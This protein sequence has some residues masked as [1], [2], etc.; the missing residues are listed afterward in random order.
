MRVLQHGVLHHPH[1]RV[2]LRATLLLALLCGGGLAV[3]HPAAAAPS[4]SWSAPQEVDG[5][6]ALRAVS[7]PS[8][9]LCVAVD[10]AG[11]AVV[12]ARA[13]NGAWSWSTFAIDGGRPLSSVSCPST[14]LCVAV[15][16]EGRA[17]VGVDP[18]VGPGAWSPVTIDAA[19]PLASISCPSNGL[20][21]AVDNKG[22]VLA[23][24]NPAAAAPGA[25]SAPAAIA[26][27][28]TSVSCAS[29]ALC[30][31]VDGEGHALTS[32]EPTA[33]AGAWHRRLIDPALGLTAVSCYAGGS[34]VA[35]DGVGNALASAD[36]PAN[37]GP[38]AGSGAT[39]SA[40]V[41]D[42]AGAPSATSCA[43]TGLCVAVDSAGYAF[44]SDSS[45]AAPPTWSARNIDSASL[46]GASCTVEGLCA[47]V[48]ASGRVLT[49]Q[50]PAPLA[51]TASAAEI[52]HTTALLTGTV[53]PNDAGL[54]ACRFEYGRSPSTISEAGVTPAVGATYEASAPCTS[55]P[56][57]SAPAPVDAVL[58][59]LTPDTTYRYRLVASTAV[60]TSEGAEATFRTLAP[61]LV[62]PHPSISGTPAPGQRLTCK[63][64]VTTTT[65][66]TLAYTWLRDTRAI[67]GAAVSSY[68]VSNA[69]VTHH[70]QCR[71]SAT[72]SEGARSATSAFVTVP[73]GGLGTLSET[74]VGTPHAGRNSVSVPVK[75]SAQ[76]A[77][78]C[79]LKLRLTVL[80]TLQGN[81]VLALA[82]RR[83]TVTVGARTAR[84]KPGQ[85]ATLTVSLN[86]T[87]RRLL[88][89]RR[90]L[91]MHLSVGGTVLGAISASLR[92]TTVTLSSS[93]KAASR[94]TSR[95]KR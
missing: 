34:C 5:G 65:A 46:T 74:T 86:T 25:W 15:D 9:T 66:V 42:T 63:S 89:Q 76:A 28:L 27:T 77:G 2:K 54:S 95:G 39:W 14:A 53:D 37:V 23:S 68:T 58:A 84:L 70:L 50:L 32:S 57:G 24:T 44:A 49:A 78:S 11:R 82:A 20:C 18:S 91:A 52:S 60:G 21:L 47:A 31:A 69:D 4:L 29:A 7:C 40:T 22:N 90:R 3:A 30:V 26:T 80:E 79:T 45:A 56:N 41:F 43:A 62:E 85:Q 19:T 67:A 87:G 8:D 81:R 61:N 6:H 17:V 72:T 36:A 59:N 13:A 71:V 94:R 33:G 35:V 16:G 83:V 88:A 64:G 48:D 51:S 10:D 73:A 38:G 75:C 92:S 55:S 1:P 93:G 12:G